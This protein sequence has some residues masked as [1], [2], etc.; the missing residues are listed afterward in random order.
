MAEKYEI[1][2]QTPDIELNSAGTGFINGWQIAYKITTGP[3]KGTPGTVFVG[4]DQ[5][6][7]VDVASIIAAEIQDSHEIAQ[8]GDG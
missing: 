5:H 6:N 1:V 2:S 3:A 8:L 7:A 4:K